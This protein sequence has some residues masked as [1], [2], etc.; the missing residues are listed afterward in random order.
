MLVHNRQSVCQENLQLQRL[1]HHQRQSKL[2]SLN[3]CNKSPN[4]CNNHHQISLIH[5][6][7]GV[8]LITN[9]QL[10]HRHFPKERYCNTN[11]LLAIYNPINGDSPHTWS[12]KCRC[13]CIN[14]CK[15]HFHNSFVT[16][17]LGG[18]TDIGKATK[19]KA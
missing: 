8:T 19:L 5:N 1:L 11:N 2:Y 4:W 7:V 15:S 18:V 12:R 14:C 3:W 9:N 13:F 6:Q 10:I 17:P 16:P